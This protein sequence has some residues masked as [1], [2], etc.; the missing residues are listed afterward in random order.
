MQLLYYCVCSRLELQPQLVTQ[1]V[2]GGRYELLFSGEIF[3]VSK[4][5]VRD[6][7][8]VESRMIG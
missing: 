5:L 8:V 4:Q 2:V 3:L 6:R 7:R 1:M